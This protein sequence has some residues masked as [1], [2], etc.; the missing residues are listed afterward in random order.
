MLTY[1]SGG[2]FNNING[3]TVASLTINANTTGSVYSGIYYTNNTIANLNVRF[4]ANAA[5]NPGSSP[6]S[7]TV[8]IRSGV[9]GSNII[10]SCYFNN[11]AT[12]ST[13]STDIYFTIPSS[14]LPIST[15]FQVVLKVTLPTST[16]DLVVTDFAM[17]VN[18]GAVQK[19]NA[20]LPVSF[21][22]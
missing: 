20:S 21:F 18:N 22:P 4:T 9:N 15:N 14:A 3:S 13:G 1:Q 17:E 12:V 2:I 6:S 16:K 11:P 10:N 8:E 19:A 5:H 7:Y